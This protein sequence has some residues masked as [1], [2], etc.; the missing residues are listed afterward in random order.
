MGNRGLGL[1]KY[2]LIGLICF[3]LVFCGLTAVSSYGTS[4]GEIRLFSH[5]IEAN[6][7]TVIIGDNNNV[8]PDKKNYAWLLIVPI[9][10]GLYLF[11]TSDV[12]IYTKED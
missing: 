7:S 8:Q 4:G 1:K 9:G 2:L 3:A 6:D 10:I 12:M 5:D 11:A